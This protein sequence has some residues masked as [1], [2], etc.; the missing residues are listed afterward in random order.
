MSDV[1]YN[2]P[3]ERI[4][5]SE[6]DPIRFPRRNCDAGLWRPAQGN[7]SDL[8]NSF[9]PALGGTVDEIK[10]VP[11][12]WA[13][14]RTFAEAVL[15][16]HHPLADSSVSRW[17]GLLA[18]LALRDACSDIYEI[19]LD[20][21]NLV[22]SKS[23]L[24]RI[25]TVLTPAMSLRRADAPDTPCADWLDPVL[26]RLTL[27][28][29]RGGQRATTV[30]L[31]MM[32]PACLVSPGRT[33][34]AVIAPQIEWMRK[35]LTDPTTLTGAD[36]LP[37]VKLAIIR[38]YVEAILADVTGMAA[39]NKVRR[40]LVAEL[41]AYRDALPDADSLPFDIDVSPRETPGDLPQL[42]AALR[43]TVQARHDDA[44]SVSECRIALRGDLPDV[45]TDDT[46][47][48]DQDDASDAPAHGAVRGVVLVD[49]AIAATLG[50]EAHNVHVWGEHTLSSLQDPN[51]FRTARDAAAAEGW[52]LIRPDQLFA[53]VLA[54]LGKDKTTILSNPEP[55]RTSPIPLTPLAL[56]L[57]D[58]DALKTRVGLAW[59]G[60]GLAKVSLEVTLM[61]PG[62]SRPDDDDHDTRTVTHRAVRIYADKPKDDQ[63]LIRRD[64][65]WTFG[66]ATVWPNFASRDW[67]HYFARFYHPEGPNRLRGRIALSGGQLA[68]HLADTPL[69]E[70]ARELRSWCRA[71]SSD[72]GKPSEAIGVL[73]GPSSYE[74]AL[75]RWSARHEGTREDIQTST[76]PF[77]AVFFTA[78]EPCGLVLLA[79]QK[80]DG[81]NGAGA[82]VGLDFGTTNTVA[83]IDN[84]DR[85]IFKDRL[86]HPVTQA[87]SKQM[88]RNR[89][90]ARMSF[91]DFLPAAEKATP[92]ASVSIDRIIDDAA[93]RP[94]AGGGKVGASD[95]L[96]K[97]A[98]YF[99]PHNTDGGDT[100]LSDLAQM[101]DILGR[102][103]FNLKWDKK[104]TGKL[105][106]QRFLGQL[107][108]MIAA[109]VLAVNRVKPANVH[110]R[111]SRPDAMQD[112]HDKFKK[113]V[114]TLLAPPGGGGLGGEIDGIYS[115]A[116][117]AGQY[118][119]DNPKKFVR[120]S[121]NI[122]LD[123]GG[124]TTD[125]TIWRGDDQV[126]K[127]S[128][129]I[130]GKSF[131]TQ[132]IVNNTGFLSNFGLPGWASI[133]KS[134][135]DRGDKF[136]K[137]V[138]EL[139]FS[140]PALSD[141]MSG[142]NWINKEDYAESRGLIH[143]GMVFLGGIAFYLGLV[144]RPLI[145]KGVIQETDLDRTV[146][147]LCGRGAG[148]FAQLHPGKPEADTRISRL[149]RLFDEGARIDQ[150]RRPQIF[151]SDQP[152]LE[153]AKGMATA[154]ALQLG[155]RGKPDGLVSLEPTGVGARIG[156]TN[157]APGD[158]IEL[159]KTKGG[160]AE[161]DMTEFERF[162]DAL[163]R[164]ADLALDLNAGGGQSTAI[165]IQECIRNAVADAQH[166]PEEE[167]R[168]ARSQPLF[169]IAL[170]ALLENMTAA[171]GDSRLKITDMAS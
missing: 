130:A 55:F 121:L 140:G 12:P 145:E 129:T 19:S 66:E 9:P 131:F 96:Q 111:F 80:V 110:W 56:L 124:G 5:A 11:D 157:Y 120:G 87:D 50:K 114:A 132:Y 1:T 108:M 150:P 147:A 61:G 22:K 165:A 92:T 139:L 74:V 153:V 60:A 35:G 43:R 154:S 166:T 70:R 16:S 47:A 126:W 17:R 142:I 163:S 75:S 25:L 152:K 128:Y 138:G 89:T 144:V 88:E 94:E 29:E 18:L 115:E 127:G 67:R 58:P 33:H 151:R 90:N 125:V 143:S 83:C 161:I 21:V 85:V 42:Y 133:L 71:P 76:I 158:T 123:I 52:L 107:L 119:L 2:L 100:S 97:Q 95:I 41:I 45:E 137:D 54:V 82:V 86:I 59:E 112:E 167:A 170:A 169:I 81:N 14:P 118:I 116:E 134:L 105:A 101:G 113:V 49:L 106:A 98:V 155:R 117:A 20:P 28:G 136:T 23:R 39:D 30:T 79:P 62:G 15:D 31:G 171:P 149:L 44:V 122:I 46:V 146:F 65:P 162:I 7:L 93:M 156:Q 51:V 37:D 40:D 84:A 78:T 102:S 57:Q 160:L 73:V 64:V 38:E 4:R 69:P 36:R 77:E 27:K 135:N 13:Q 26:L 109:E 32:N 103:H 3:A 72:A 91:L 24:A 48:R 148:L 6:D 10:S 99:H 168:N 104:E 53:P 63:G 68:R 164:H 159:F 141:A 8:G 34:G